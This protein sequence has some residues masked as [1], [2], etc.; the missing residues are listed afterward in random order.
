MFHVHHRQL[1]GSDVE[2]FC[3]T[4][5]NNDDGGGGFI[6]FNCVC[7]VSV[8]CTVRH[9]TVYFTIQLEHLYL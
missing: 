1:N 7:I 8:A 5:R 2:I 6:G 4:V 9:C 3:A